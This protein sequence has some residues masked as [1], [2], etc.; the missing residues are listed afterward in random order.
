MIRRIEVFYDGSCEPENP[1]GR[2]GW[3]FAVYEDGRKIHAESNGAPPAAKNTCNTAEYKAVAAALKWL[4]EKELTGAQ[5]RMN[6]DS[7][8]TVNQMNGR[9]KFKGGAYA[10][11]YLVALGLTKAFA[12]IHFTWIPRERNAEAD[13]LSK[14]PLTSKES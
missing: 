5:V 7:L 4:I 1:G 12:D 14:A 3:G 8:L 13:E 2:M 6:G 11:A 10:E 9:W